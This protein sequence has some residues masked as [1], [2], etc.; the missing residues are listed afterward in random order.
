MLR[1]SLITPTVFLAI[2]ALSG[3]SAAPVA[4]PPE[5][6]SAAPAE[7][8]AVTGVYIRMALG[9]D[10]LDYEIYDSSTMDPI[11]FDRY[12][13]QTAGVFTC[14]VDAAGV[15]GTFI[16]VGYDLARIVDTRISSLGQSAY[17]V[18]SRTDA[19][20]VAEAIIAQAR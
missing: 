2:V 5:S 15:N 10:A 19:V 20:A 9:V 11:W 13:T 7:P 3:C 8:A 17:Q 4:G 1:R 18:E 6:A 16:T 14:C 12:V